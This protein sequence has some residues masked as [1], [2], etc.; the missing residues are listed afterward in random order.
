[1]ATVELAVVMPLLVAF[2]LG[3]WELSRVV[4][5]GQVLGNAAR[6]GARQAAAGRLTN[7]Q[8]RTIVTRYVSAAGLPTTHL[9]VTVAN[10]AN[11]NSD[12]SAASQFDP[13]KVN[14][15]IPFGD[16]RLISASLFNGAA[17]P[18]SAQATW[19]SLKDKPYPDP[20]DPP[21]E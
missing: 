12:V 8:I 7:S 5:A 15:S 16:V 21:I 13:V 10:L 3:I 11:I 14:A 19:Y 20:D 2:L 18:I 6:E 4:L 1:M 9:T 17:T